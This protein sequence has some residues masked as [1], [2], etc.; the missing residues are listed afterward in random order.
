MM[1]QLKLKSKKTWK[2]YEKNPPPT[3]PPPCVPPP[4]LTKKE[5]EI[6]RNKANKEFIKT[7]LLMN[8]DELDAANESADQKNKKNN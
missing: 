8:K 2:T 4:L 6:E 1:F 3:P 7:S 5:I